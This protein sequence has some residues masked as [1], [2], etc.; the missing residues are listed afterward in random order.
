MEDKELI[1]HI[2][3]ELFE[4]W[5]EAK[6]EIDKSWE[7]T[8]F[9]SLPEK[10]KYEYY[11]TSKRIVDFFKEAGYRKVSGESLVLSDEEIGKILSKTKPIK[12]QLKPAIGRTLNGKSLN[13]IV[14]DADYE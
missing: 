3:K 6:Q 13:P 11:L 2:A 8:I 7:D 4:I 9:E 12:R 5:K 14:Q 10:H 1:E